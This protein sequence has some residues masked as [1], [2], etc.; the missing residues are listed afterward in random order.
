MTISF[1][2]KAISV[3]RCSYTISEERY[4]SLPREVFQIWHVVAQIQPLEE[5]IIPRVYPVTENTREFSAGFENLL[6][7]RLTDPHSAFL[8]PTAQ[9]HL[10]T[11]A[12]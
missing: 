8:K 3:P 9:G 6:K 7:L 2:I 4:L 12:F 1:S 5:Q 11:Q 10:I